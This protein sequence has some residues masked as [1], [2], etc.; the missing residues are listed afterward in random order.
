MKQLKSN[1]GAHCKTL[2]SANFRNRKCILITSGTGLSLIV[3]VGHSTSADYY[4]G[5]KS[6]FG[7]LS[8]FLCSSSPLLDNRYIQYQS[9]ILEKYLYIWIVYYSSERALYRDGAR[10]EIW[11]GKQKCSAPP[12]HGGTF[13]SA[14]TWVGNCPLCLTIIDAP[15]KIYYIATLLSL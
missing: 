13:Y 3:R 2:K 1:N 12:Q 10:S 14:K 8:F 7:F 9:W 6:N 5:R 11:V 15:I 4:G